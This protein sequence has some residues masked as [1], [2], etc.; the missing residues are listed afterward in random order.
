MYQPG[1]ATEDG[2]YRPGYVTEDRA[3]Q[4]DRGA[5]PHRPGH[6]VGDGGYRPRYAGGDDAFRP[7]YTGRDEDFRSDYAGG[8]EAYRPGY[9]GGD[10]AYPTGYTAGADAY[11]TNSAAG[12]EPY[13]ARSPR[14]RHRRPSRFRAASNARRREPAGSGGGTR[15]ATARRL[16]P[17]LIICGLAA[18]AVVIGVVAPGYRVAP[19]AP[20]AA[21]V[22]VQRAAV[23]PPAVEP[24]TVERP[25]RTTTRSQRQPRPAPAASPSPKREPAKPVRI[26]G[27]STAQ[28]ANAALIVEVGRQRGLPRRGQI[29]AIATAMQ[30]SSLRNLANPTVPE[31]LK[32]TNQGTGTDFDSVGVFQQRPSQGWGSVEQLMSPRYA[33]SVFYERLVKVPGWENMTVTAAAQAVQRSGLP[34]AYAKHEGRATQI[35]SALS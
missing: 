13:E 1:Y 35:V 10:E 18:I 4:R 11:P 19:G 21:A 20:Q 27:L 3:R 25:V 30:E 17:V 16:L 24:P 9:A 29:V 15:K 5:D 34:D 31:S 6:A 26:Q 12:D 33:A 32:H 14:V 22:T 28:A 2:T 7:G 8:D 23:E